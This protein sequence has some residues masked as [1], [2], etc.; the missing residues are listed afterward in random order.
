MAKIKRNC[1]FCNKEFYANQCDIKRGGGK[2]CSLKCSLSG[3]HNPRWNGGQAKGICEI[4]NTE[5][6]TR[7]CNLR[8][9]R[10]RFCSRQCQNQWRSDTF[11]RNKHPN[12]QGGLTPIHLS[13]R[14][15]KKYA[16]WRQTIFIR[17]NFTCKECGNKQSGNLNAHHKKPFSILLKEAQEYLPLMDIYE[18]VMTYT[19]I[20][21]LD[22]G[23]TLCKD[24]HEKKHC[25]DGMD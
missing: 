13:I 18:A 7:Q 21:D 15:S 12:W 6:S 10:A 4:C 17:D 11:K 20:W 25:K 8:S 19:P 22:N 3:K 2:F 14:H 24:C 9:G 23:I 5:F 16:D 1:Q